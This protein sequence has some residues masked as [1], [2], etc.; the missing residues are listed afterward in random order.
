MASFVGLQDLV[1]ALAG[2]VID[3]QRQVDRAQI[4]NLAGYLDG[5]QRP[6]M[7]NLR[8]PSLRPEAAPGDEDLYQVPLLG[9]VAHSLLRIKQLEV[10]FDVE[11]GD[12]SDAAPAQ[13]AAAEP[14][15]A[16]AAAA[17]IKRTLSVNPAVTAA[18]KQEG[19]TAHVVLTME[20]IEQ[21]EGI[22]RMVSELTRIQGVVGPAP[23]E[24]KT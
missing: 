19:S 8:V 14:A 13:K 21:P 4:A 15:A 11:L 7:L 20:A 10:S 18:V 12:L 24:Q 9:L 1:H 22:A 5:R 6:Q 23:R 16:G 2:A 17:D 3:A